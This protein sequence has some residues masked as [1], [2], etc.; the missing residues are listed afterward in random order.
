MNVL[1]PCRLFSEHQVSYNTPSSLRYSL[2]RP[3]SFSTWKGPKTELSDKSNENRP[4]AIPSFCYSVLTNAEEVTNI[5]SRLPHTRSIL[6]LNL[7]FF[8][9][10]FQKH[11]VIF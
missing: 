1:Y 11:F 5:F 7:F 8:F 2:C 6:G 9:C 3:L 4:T 10:Y